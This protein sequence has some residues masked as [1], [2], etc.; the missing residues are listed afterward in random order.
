MAESLK[1]HFGAI[2]PHTIARQIEAVWPGFRPEPFMTDVLQGYEPLGLMDRGRHVGRM[3]RRYLPDDYPAA[4]DILLRSVDDR[5]ER[6][7]GDG[8]MASFLYL[9]HVSFV[10]EFGLDYFDESMEALYVLTQRFTSEFSIR[11]FI[12][13]YEDETLQVLE[14]WA[15]DPNVH[16]RR[17]VSEGT[18]PR[19]PWASRL[20]RFQEDPS[21]V[22]ALLELLKDDPSPYVRRSVANNLN[23]IGKD[24][25]DILLDVAG[26]WLQDANNERTGLVRHALRSLVKQGNPEALTLLGYGEPASVSIENIEILPDRVKKGGRVQVRFDVRSVGRRPQNVLLDLRVHFVKATG[27]ASPKVFKLKRVELAPAEVTS[28]RKTISVEDL[29]TRR[30]YAGKHYMDV[31]LNGRA[32]EIGA[33]ELLE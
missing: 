5:P 1:N 22:A 31:L 16:V 12:E 32:R 21:P 13:R 30:H 10:A 23:D 6:T 19:L 33:F 15:V 4:L 26:R 25:P 17:L 27:T 3:L 2:V 20:R 7:E 9:P 24:H 14:R 18:R 8:G 29:T 28:C 11:P